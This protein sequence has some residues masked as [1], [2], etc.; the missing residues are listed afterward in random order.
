MNSSSIEQF[1]FQHSYNPEHA[2]FYFYKNSGNYDWDT[3]LFRFGARDYDAEIG[4]WLEWDQILYHR[5]NMLCGSSIFDKTKK[6]INGF[7]GKKS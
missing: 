7:L 4:R 5:F 6:E 2:D 3:G 1:N